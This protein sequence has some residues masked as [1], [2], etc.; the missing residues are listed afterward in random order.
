MCREGSPHWW[1][2]APS[3]FLAQSYS[4]VKNRIA[5]SEVTAPHTA[6]TIKYSADG[7]CPTLVSVNP[8]TAAPLG[9]KLEMSRSH[10]GMLGRCHHSP[11]K[12][13]MTK[14]RNEPKP[15]A[16]LALWNRLA[17]SIPRPS[18]AQAPSR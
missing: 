4:Q 14:N 10:V 17:I 9:V 2:P 5:S 6:R 1:L 8:C 16:T 13:C 18:I 15:A 3:E 12:N 7:Q 11:A